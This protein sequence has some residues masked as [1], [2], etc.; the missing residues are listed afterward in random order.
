M[1][2][3]KGLVEAESQHIETIAVEAVLVMEMTILRIIVVPP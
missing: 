1:M 2:I 3:G